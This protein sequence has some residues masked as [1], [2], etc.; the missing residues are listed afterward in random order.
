MKAKVVTPGKILQVQTDF[1]ATLPVHIHKPAGSITIKGEYSR[2]VA[3]KAA[4]MV[5]QQTRAAGS[6]ERGDEAGSQ[7]TNGKLNVSNFNQNAGRGARN[8]KNNGLR[9]VRLFNYATSQAT[10][11]PNEP[12]QPVSYTHLTLPT[13][14]SV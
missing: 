3:A 10:S 5:Q 11:A 4:G 13:I 1:N 9:P 8:S 2:K 6:V 14:C 12:L 7:D